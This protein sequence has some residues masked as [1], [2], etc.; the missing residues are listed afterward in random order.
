MQEKAEPVEILP[1][2]QLCGDLAEEL[3]S[4]QDTKVATLISSS[5]YLLF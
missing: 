3:E 4:Y 2:T 5:K 1:V